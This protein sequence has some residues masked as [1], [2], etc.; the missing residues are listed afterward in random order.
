M[1]IDSNTCKGHSV[2]ETHFLSQSTPDIF[3]NRDKAEVEKKKK[4][5]L[6]KE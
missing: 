3:N 4:H 5:G 1:D 6:R 2:F